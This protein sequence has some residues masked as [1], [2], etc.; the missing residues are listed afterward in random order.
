MYEQK[1]KELL[2]ERA[3]QFH[4]FLLQR[5]SAKEISK[6][7]KEGGRELKEALQDRYEKN[8]ENVVVSFKYLGSG[9]VV[10]RTK[11]GCF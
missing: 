2:K 7:L 5:N 8:R 1:I 4:K 11:R 3:S 6:K 10:K 9:R